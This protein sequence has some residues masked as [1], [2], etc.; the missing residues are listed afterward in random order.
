MAFDTVHI[1][2]L[3]ARGN[4]GG[5]NQQRYYVKLIISTNARIV[6]TLEATL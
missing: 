4:T 6:S 3:L 5:V 2:I 1:A